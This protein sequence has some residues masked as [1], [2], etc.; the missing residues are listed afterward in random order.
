M[1]KSAYPMLTRRNLML[2]SAMLAVGAALGGLS[3]GAAAQVKDM[4]MWYWGEQ[5]LPG[6]QVWG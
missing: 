3:K 1:T 6:L 5:E 2:T 4:D